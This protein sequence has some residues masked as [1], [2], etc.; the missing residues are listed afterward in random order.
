VHVGDVQLAAPAIA[1]LTRLHNLHFTMDY[2][3]FSGRNSTEQQ[4]DAAV[5]AIAQHWPGLTRLTTLSIVFDQ[6]SGAHPRAC[7]PSAAAEARLSVRLAPLAPRLML[8]G[9]LW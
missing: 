3:A 2:L 4:S 7:R 9:G 6:E 8:E 5:F 1:M